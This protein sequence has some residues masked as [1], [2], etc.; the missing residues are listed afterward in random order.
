MGESG[1]VASVVRNGALLGGTLMAFVGLWW[2]R[3]SAA[4]IVVGGVL[5]CVGAMSAR[6]VEAVT[7]ESV[8]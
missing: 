4:L 3:P 6:R 8:T 5:A 2:E 7:E 1:L